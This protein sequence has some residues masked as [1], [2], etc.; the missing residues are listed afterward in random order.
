MKDQP[1][2]KTLTPLIIAAFCGGV[3]GLGAARVLALELHSALFLRIGGAALL[4]V[5]GAG[6]AAGATYALALPALAL[7]PLLLPAVDLLAGDFVPWRGPVLL[8]GSMLLTIANLQ[9]LWPALFIPLKGT[10]PSHH[11]H[12]GRIKNAGSSF[13]KVTNGKAP[14]ARVHD[15][16]GTALAVLLPLLIYLPDI[17]PYVGRADTFEFQVI[18]PRL[19]IAHPSGYPLYILVGKLFSLL[20]LGAVAW[21]VN[22]SSAVCAALAAGALYRT[23]APL[24]GD[25]SKTT[26]APLLAALTLAFSPTLWA[27][28]IEAETYALNALLVALGL[29]LATQWAA[30]RWDAARALPAFGLLVGVGMASHLTLGALGL[31]A[32]PLLITAK[33]RPRPRTLLAAAGLGLLGLALY[34]YIPLRWP[35]INGEWMTP[36]HFLRFVTN[37]ESGGALRPLAFW[38]DPA[39]W[40]LV[41]KRLLAQ[42]SWPGLMLALV[43]LLRLARRRWSLALGTALSFA[44]W[45]WFNLSFYVADPDYSAFLIPAHVVLIFWMGAGIESLLARLARFESSPANVMRLVFLPLL[46]LSRLWITGP[47]LDT[48]SQGREDEAWGRYAL[49]QPVAE[50]AAILADSEK[51]PPLYY[52]QQIESLRPDLELVTLFNEAQYR[53]DMEARLAAGQRVYLARYLPGLDGYGGATSVGPLVEVAPPAITPTADEGPKFGAA[54]RLRDHTLE[55]DPEGRAMHHLTLTWE[56]A[57]APEADLTIRLRLRE[58]D[59]DEIAWEREATRPVNGYTTTEAWRAGQIVRDYH[60]L[61][62]PAWLPADE[63]EL[64]VAVAPRFAETNGESWH[65]LTRVTV[66]AQPAADLPR[67]VGAHFAGAD[68]WLESADVPGEV[69]A[70][71]PLAIDLT[72]RGDTA[73]SGQPALTWQPQEHARWF[74]PVML[75]AQ[76]AAASANSN[77]ARTRRY[78]VEAPSLPGRYRLYI[79]WHDETGSPV[80]ARCAW[81]SAPATMCLLAEVNVGPSNAGLANFDQRILLVN[82]DLDAS[83]VPAGG[84]LAVDLRWRSLREMAHDYTVFVQVIGPDGQLYGQVDSW[85]VQGASP[86]SQWR[87]GEEIDDRYRFYVAPDAPPGEH[88]VIVGWYRLADMRRLPV[89]N[90]AGQIIGDFHTLGTFEIPES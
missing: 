64:E 5:L 55:A 76:G 2:A 53:A 30:N 18:A 72:W 88:Q 75:E 89:R 23:L 63:Y 16:I 35:A 74:P 77:T 82:A 20:P 54:L 26:L 86:T 47:T 66:P 37:A 39:R 22:L 51:F 70:E 68:L 46:P 85:P 73:T 17:S 48:L 87:L 78:E 45:I 28:A 1:N 8:G 71:A 62:W 65:R 7:L 42:V 49:R 14:F 61:D 21:R 84:Q 10:P 50:G 27:R 32:L 60:A 90:Q 43:G 34:L 11:E 58:A 19:G 12:S 83:A 40:A 81:L 15:N 9:R 56:A 24:N 41:G 52:L 79:A 29:W 44:A 33:P 31:L 80:P 4:A 3:W 25:A 36:A 69:W 6:L 57:T 59:S 38:R 13:L 67:R